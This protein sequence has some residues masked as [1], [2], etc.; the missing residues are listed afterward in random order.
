MEVNTGCKQTEVGVIPEDWETTSIGVIADIHV[1]RDLHEKRFSPVSDS[2]FRFPVYSNTV[3]G[4][5]LYGFY[6]TPDYEGDSLTVVGRGVG[7]GTAF[8]RRGGYGAIGRLLV[9]MP[10]DRADAQFLATYINQRVRIFVETG[11]IPQLTGIQFSKYK[12]GLPPLPEQRAIAAVLSDVDSLLSG[13]ERLIAKKRDLKQAAMQH[14][15]TGQTRLP[16]FSGAWEVKRLGD[17][18]DM[19]SG[20]TPLSSVAAYYDGDIPWVSISDMTKGGKTIESTE[21]NLTALGFA[22]SAAQ[23]FPAGTVLYAMYASL[24]ECSIAGIPLCSSQ[25]ILGIRPRDKLHREFL[26]YYLDSL[27]ATVKTLGQQGTQ[28]NLNKGM[29]QDFRLGLPTLDEQIAIATVL[30]D[31]DAELSALEARRD[32]TRALKQ[33]MTQELLTGRTRLL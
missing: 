15:L 25:A 7:L 11:G 19:G 5:G 26:Y 4:E 6:S 14:L 2:T 28:A 20:G 10:N 31:M 21:R 16:G 18:A 30:S 32:K 9:L 17:L 24:G 33:A 12:V 8:A 29:V 13:L 27:K 3:A 23:M 1:G 22:N